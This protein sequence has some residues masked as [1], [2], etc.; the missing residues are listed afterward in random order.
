MIVK[1]KTASGYSFAIDSRIKD[2]IDLSEAAIE[3]QFGESL[4][5]Q[6][7]A[8]KKMGRILLGSDENVQKLKDTIRKKNDGFCSNEAFYAEINEIIE[9]M[10]AKNS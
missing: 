9:A 3:V 2:D 10:N 4:I 5:D 1:G 7:N 6:Y 8:V